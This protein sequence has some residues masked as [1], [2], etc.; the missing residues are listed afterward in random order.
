MTLWAATNGGQM[1]LISK[2]DSVYGEGRIQNLQKCGRWNSY[3]QF[4]QVKIHAIDFCHKK[5][6]IPNMGSRTHKY[7]RKWH[8]R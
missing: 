3:Q 4:G 7:Q 2:M 8:W 5:Q 1:D 6:G